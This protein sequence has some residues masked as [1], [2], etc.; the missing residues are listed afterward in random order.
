MGLISDFFT[1]RIDGHAARETHYARLHGFVGERTAERKSTG[2]VNHTDN[3]HRIR[4]IRLLIS[5]L[6]HFINFCTKYNNGIFLK[7]AQIFIDVFISFLYYET[8]L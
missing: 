4:V 5:R 6:C 2:L 7:F 1:G 8:I 3:E